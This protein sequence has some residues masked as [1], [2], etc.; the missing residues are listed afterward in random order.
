MNLL[1]KLWRRRPAITDAGGLADFID[2][3]AAFLVQ[4]GMYEYSRARA[5]HFSK[6]MFGELEFRNAIESSRWRAYPIGL[7]MV[8]EVAVGVI[9]Q[10]AR[11][12][13]RAVLADVAPIVLSVFDRYARPDVLD[14]DTW[15][16]ARQTLAG[17]L[18]RIGL[19]PAKRAMDIPEPLAESYFDLMP[20]HARLRGPDFPTLK[21][22]LRVTLCN[23]HDELAKRIDVAAIADRLQSARG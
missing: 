7:A 5:G 6:V 2:E 23:I 1:E 8:A 18:D 13:R 15:R 4:K 14:A 20:I 17:H 12:E 11:L 22:Y 9:E 19:H 3:Q 16:Q 21:N 10:E